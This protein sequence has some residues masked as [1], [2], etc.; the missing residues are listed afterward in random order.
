MSNRDIQSRQDVEILVHSFYSK[1]RKHEG[2]G[3]FFNEVIDDWSLHIKRFTDFWHSNLFLSKTYKGKTLKA[4]ISVDNHFSHNLRDSHFK[5]W[6]EIW[7]QS[8]NALFFGEK[9][10]QAK[11]R[12][13]CM[14]HMMSRKVVAAREQQRSRRVTSA[15]CKKMNASLKTSYQTLQ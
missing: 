13:H 14:A 8:V 7:N 15:I 11:K 1:V 10:N 6:V 5:I 2:L 3:P 12:A 9:A 4:H